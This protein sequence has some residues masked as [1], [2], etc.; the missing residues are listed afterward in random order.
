MLFSGI[1][2]GFALTGSFCKIDEVFPE[3]KKL[4]E[5]GAEVFPIVSDSVFRTDTRFGRAADIIKKL[6][7]LTGKKV[8]SSIVEAEPI[9]PKSFLDVLVVA[10][11]TG[12][13]LGK[14]ANGITDNAVTMSVK[15]HL[16]NQK[17]V[18]IAVSTNDGLGA[19]AKNIGLLM[20]TKNYYFVPF[21]QDDPVKKCNS[22]VAK[23]DMI[24]P[25]I[26]GA[27]KGIQ[28]QPVLV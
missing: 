23:M 2:A 16:R 18:V 21:G 5:E 28:V 11:C 8:I 19:N 26:A 20:N 22:L 12:N 27:L 10:P 17:P 25:T 3:I 6:E 15:A 24:L 4:V 7:E 1:K 9:G 14:L 13:T